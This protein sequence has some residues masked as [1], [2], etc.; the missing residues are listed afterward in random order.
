MGRYKRL[1]ESLIPH[2]M[3][4]YTPLDVRDATGHMAIKPCPFWSRRADKDEQESGHCAFMD[5]GDWETGGL[6]WDQVKE[7]GVNDECDE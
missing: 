2:G 5:V 4:C 1:C 6:L 7:C 3:Y